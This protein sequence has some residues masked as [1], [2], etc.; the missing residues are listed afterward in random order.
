MIHLGRIILKHGSHQQQQT[1]VHVAS[2]TIHYHRV[3]DPNDHSS[4]P[5]THLTQLECSDCHG[6]PLT[7]AHLMLCRGPTALDF[8]RDLLHSILDQGFSHITECQHWL[9]HAKDH[10]DLHD[11]M[12]WL[13]PPSARLTSVDERHDHTIRCMIGAFTIGQSTSAMLRLG[14]KDLKVGQSAF[15]T[16]RQVCLQHIGQ[17]Y[18]AIKQQQQQQQQQ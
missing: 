12:I 4:S 17:F 10:V 15:V 9:S 3:T 1:F 7:L 8:H 18:H 6:Q 2:N 16:I 14:I 13:F 5:S 11:L